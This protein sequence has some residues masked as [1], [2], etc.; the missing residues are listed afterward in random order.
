MRGLV[1]AALL[2][3]ASA[4]WWPMVASAQSANERSLARSQFRDGLEAAQSGDWESAFESFQSSYALV[5]R[6]ITL[7]NLAGAMVQTGR[8][9]EGA[10]AYRRFIRQAR[11]GRPAQH[12]AA[13]EQALTELE[14]RI[15]VVEL[16]VLGFQEGDALSL[17]GWEVSRAV[18]DEELPVDPGEHRVTVDREGHEQLVVEFEIREG[19]TRDVVVDA[20]PEHWVPVGGRP[21]PEGD[22]ILGEDTTT[23]TAQESSSSI[24]SSPWFWIIAG[25]VVAA[26]VVIPIVIV[27]S[28]EQRDPVMGNLSPFRVEIN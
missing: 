10:E 1:A 14:G 18:L 26:A 5:Q 22:Q 16:R 6:P 17:D 24:F 4:A 25:V 8:L 12:R 9:V 23:T 15:P 19:A 20:T 2:V 27:T 3:V 28:G 13:A 7:L 11:R 21:T